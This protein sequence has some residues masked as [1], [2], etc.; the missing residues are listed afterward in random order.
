MC[1]VS[2]GVFHCNAY[3]WRLASRDSL[4]GLRKTRLLPSRCFGDHP[5]P[6]LKTSSCSLVGEWNIPSL[7]IH[8]FLNTFTHTSPDASPKRFHTL[9]TRFH[10]FSTRHHASSNACS[11]RNFPCPTCLSHRYVT[12]CIPL[13]SD[14]LPPPTQAPLSHLLPLPPWCVASILNLVESHLPPLV[15]WDG[16]A[17][18]SGWD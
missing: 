3:I 17:E 10:T 13:R 16:R 2:L 15:C 4:P 11:H 9:S 7:N 1:L 5:M 6:P 14:R 12:S 8:T 18:V